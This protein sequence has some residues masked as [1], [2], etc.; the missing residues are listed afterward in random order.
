[1]RD[2]K[3]IQVEKMWKDIENSYLKLNILMAGKTGVGKTSLVN[4]IIGEEVGQVAKDGKPATRKNNSDLLWSTDMGDIRFTDVPGFGEASAPTLNGVDYEENICNLGKTAHILLLVISCS[5][6]ALEKE[7]EFLEKWKQDPDLAKVPVFIVINKIDSMK[8]IREWN[9]ETLNLKHPTTEKEIQIKSFIDYVSGLPT[10]KEYAYLGHVYPV[11]AGEEWGKDTYGIDVLK[12]AI[13][14]NVPEML[15]LVL[16]RENLSK[17]EKA[18]KIIRNYALSAATIAVEPIPVVDSVLLAPVQVAMVLHL[19]KIYGQKITKTAAQGIINTIG[20]SFIGNVLFMTLA[21]FFPGVKQII[22]PSVA[23]SLTYVSGLI[24]N[25]LFSSGNINP[26][27]EQL[28]ELS[29]KYKGELKKAK[30]LYE[31]NEQ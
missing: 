2:T 24:I 9:P 18:K 26:T 31:E 13:N 22:G 21:G 16:E 3:E 12:Q 7:K 27:K 23:F 1:M 15:R 30:K 14:N 25:D 4:A 19:G 29:Q 5:D 10:F 6:K 20:L 17:E 28:Q 8:P 11:C